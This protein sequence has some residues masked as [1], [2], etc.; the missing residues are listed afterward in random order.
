MEKFKVGDRYMLDYNSDFNIYQF[1]SVRC[2]GGYIFNW[3]N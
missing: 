3:L 1:N 2:N